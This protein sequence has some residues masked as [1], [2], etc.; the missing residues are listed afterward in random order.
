MLQPELP[1]GRVLQLHRKPLTPG[2]RGLPKH[3]VPEVRLTRAGVVGDHNV[4][5]HDVAGDDPAMAVLIM[6]EEMLADLNAKGWPIRPGDIGE[7]L[8]SVGL[9]Y[10]E[11]APGRRYRAGEALLEISKPC[12]P[13][14]NLYLLPYVGAARGPEFLK[15]MLDRRG[16]YARVLEEGRVKVGDPIVRVE[17]S[18]AG[19]PRP[20][21][22]APIR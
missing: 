5:R 20:R 10:D 21:V 18:D 1:R 14:D 17:R 8:T 22:G 11:F 7:N 13:C 2:E 3:A 16:W 19:G 9:P 12:T 4:Y 6:P 15:V